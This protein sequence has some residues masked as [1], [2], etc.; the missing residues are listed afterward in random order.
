MC[1]VSTH[2]WQTGQK[3]RKKKRKEKDFTVHS[4][5]S[6]ETMFSILIDCPWM[7]FFFFKPFSFFVILHDEWGDVICVMKTIS[8]SAAVNPF[9]SI[10]IFGNHIAFFFH[11]LHSRHS[12]GRKRGTVYE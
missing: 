9:R 12:M 4:I 11:C 6:T 5:G 1:N 2:F 7:I 8:I 10:F 3:R